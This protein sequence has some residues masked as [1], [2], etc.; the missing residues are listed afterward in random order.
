MNILADENN[1]K[2]YVFH[3]GDLLGNILFTLKLNSINPTEIS[4]DLL[5][6][7]ICILLKKYTE[8]GLK[9]EFILTE[10]EI[11]R[12]IKDNK[13]IYA[14]SDEDNRKILLLREMTAVDLAKRHHNAMPFKV[15]NATVNGEVQKKVI[16]AYNDEKPKVLEKKTSN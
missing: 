5:E 16:E 10:E 13:D 6:K 14:R 2:K 4:L 8:D 11:Q 15:L 9:S 3:I 1:N 7:Y 12:F